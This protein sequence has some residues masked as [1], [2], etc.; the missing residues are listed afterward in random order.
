MKRFI[1]LP[2]ALVA[3]AASRAPAQ[4]TYPYMPPRFGP[5]WHTPLSPYLNLLIPGNSAVDY[6]SLTLP[7]IQRRQL[8]NQMFG[9]LQGLNNMLPPR[10]QLTQQEL[11]APLASTGHPTA[12]GY[13][14]S[15]FG[16]PTM[17]SPGS[18]FR[19]R[20]SNN[21][22]RNTALPPGKAPPKKR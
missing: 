13:T 8:R 2:L 20:F 3:L 9:Q 19:Q 17:G 15:Y 10:P 22:P 5:G 21:W 4:N 16:G 6:Y 14:G 18:P 7:Q 11:F 1:V 12:F